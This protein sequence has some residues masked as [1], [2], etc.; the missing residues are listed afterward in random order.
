MSGNNDR[1]TDE[2]THALSERLRSYEERSAVAQAK[3]AQA[4]GRLLNLAET[5]DSGQ[6]QKIVQFLAATYD[7]N[8]F[9]F[10]LFDLRSLDVAVS[11]D[12]LSAI[13]AVRWGKTDLYRLVPNGEK[14]VK[15]VIRMWG[16]RTTK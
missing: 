10:D 5:N 12:I 9:N 1:L 14:R 8:A 11:D 15:E 7:S 2:K 3:A 13:D 4:Y 6:I 16:L